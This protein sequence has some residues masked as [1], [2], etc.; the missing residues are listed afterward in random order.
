M[1]AETYKGIEKL[2]NKNENGAKTVLTIDKK[3]NGEP[4][5][6]GHGCRCGFEGVNVAY[7]YAVFSTIS[8]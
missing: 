7:L 5:V 4:K 1:K 6:L 8:L 3:K 2:K